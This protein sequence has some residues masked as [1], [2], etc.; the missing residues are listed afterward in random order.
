MAISRETK[1]WP[2]L[3]AALLTVLVVAGCVKDTPP[4][5]GDGDSAAAST[6]ASTT[7]PPAVTG[8]ATDYCTM[9]ERIG[10]ESGAMVNKHF[11]S[12]LKET[13]DMLKALVNLSLAAKDQLA[14]S[15]PENIRPA[16]LLEMQFFQ[17]LKDSNFDGTAV[18]PAGFD[19]ARK[20]VDD[21]G[22]SACGFVFDE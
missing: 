5:P 1:Q 17:A 15:L 11:I 18:P 21:Y 6:T 7:P 13:L 20:T 8:D 4:T 12:P 2:L 3:I 9:A 10:V 22:R 16:F 14:A 19:E